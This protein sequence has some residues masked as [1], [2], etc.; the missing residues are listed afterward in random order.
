MLLKKPLMVIIFS[1]FSRLTGTTT[2]ASWGMPAGTAMD[3][4]GVDV[5]KVNKDGQDGRTLGLCRSGRNDEENGWRKTDG[6]KDGDKDG[7]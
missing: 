2:D 3:E 7:R 4:K 1:A 6:H 5:V